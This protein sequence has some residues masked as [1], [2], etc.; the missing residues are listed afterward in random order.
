[1]EPVQDAVG[2]GRENDPGDKDD[3][4]AAVEGVEAGEDLSGVGERRID[5]PHAAEKHGSI[6][7]SVDPSQFLK[8]VVSVYS[9]EERDDDDSN[10]DDPTVG[11]PYEKLTWGNDPLGTVLKLWNERFHRV[12]V[13]FFGAF[14]PS[15]EVAFFNP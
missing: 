5:G 15:P 7:E 3:R 14:S 11:K 12:G 8:R 13:L 10:G 9:D 2:Y 6:E 1:M 4:Q